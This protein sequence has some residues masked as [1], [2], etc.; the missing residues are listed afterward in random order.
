MAFGAEQRLP[1]ISAQQQKAQHQSLTS[2]SH[3]V[4]PALPSKPVSM[5]SATSRGEKPQRINVG[6]NLS[7]VQHALKSKTFQPLSPADK[8]ESEK[9]VDKSVQDAEFKPIS[10][11]EREALY[12]S[13]LKYRKAPTGLKQHKIDEHKHGVTPLTFDEWFDNSNERGTSRNP[14]LIEKED[15]EKIFGNNFEHY[16]NS[17]PKNNRKSCKGRPKKEAQARKSESQQKQKN[18]IKEAI[19]WASDVSDPNAPSLRETGEIAVNQAKQF[20]KKTFPIIKK[21]VKTGFNGAKTGI[22]VA[23]QLAEEFEKTPMARNIIK[24]AESEYSH[25]KSAG[26]RTRESIAA[27]GNKRYLTGS[28]LNKP[29][30]FVTNPYGIVGRYKLGRGGRAELHFYRG[31]N[32][33]T[34]S[35]VAKIMTHKQIQDAKNAAILGQPAKTQAQ[36]QKYK[37]P[38]VQAQ[39]TPVLNVPNTHSSLAKKRVTNPLG[40]QAPATHSGLAKKRVTGNPIGK[41]IHRSA[42]FTIANKTITL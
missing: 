33:I 18:P 39:K 17:C 10:S 15:V 41:G 20:T 8:D 13:S 26:R 2:T 34:H 36:A 7:Q 29:R 42:P 3:V 35:K 22:R 21:I 5:V 30:V 24:N 38:Q 11:A 32:R 9:V 28:S 14:R 40:T 31:K 23:G 12:E 4:S 27:T 16:E 25:M 37:A 19:L 1:A 6:S